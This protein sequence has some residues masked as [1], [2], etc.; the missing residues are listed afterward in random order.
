VEDAQS[1]AVVAECDFVSGDGAFVAHR[2][3]PQSR[4]GRKIGQHSNMVLLELLFRRV[5][6]WSNP[7]EEPVVLTGLALLHSSQFIVY[8]SPNFDIPHKNFITKSNK[9]FYW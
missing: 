7:L 5:W 3:Q 9:Y 8:L 2:Y 4:P 6:Y 1:D